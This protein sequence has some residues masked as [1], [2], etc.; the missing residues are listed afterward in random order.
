MMD[1]NDRGLTH[2]AYRM[3]VVTLV[4]HALA[5]YAIGPVP[6]PWLAQMLAMWMFLWIG[7][8]SGLRIAPG[9]VLFVF[10]FIYA[11]LVT[12]YQ[13]IIGEYYRFMPPKA[14]TPYL[15]Y[16]AL[17]FMTMASFGSLVFVT[18]WFLVRGW[19]PQLIRLMTLL[20][21]LV[22]LAALYI[23]FAQIYGFPEP[24][25]TRLGTGGG[26]Q[27]IKFTYA[28][29]RALGTFREPSHLAEWLVLPLFMS[30]ASQ[31]WTSYAA[32][33][34]G[35][36]ALLL[37][38]SLTG[39]G[40]ILGGMAAAFI[41]MMPF[42]SMSVVKSVL[43][44][45]LIGALGLSSFSLF[46]SSNDSK[47]A[48]LIDVLSKRIKPLEEKGIGQSNRNYVY[49]YLENTEILWFGTGMGNSN[50]QFTQ[51]TG[52]DAT[53]SFL[54]L[55][56]NI[57]LSLGYIGLALFIIFLITP[58]FILFAN[59]G[60]KFEPDHFMILAAFFGWLVVFFAHSEELSFHFAMIYALLLHAFLQK[61]P[62]PEPALIQ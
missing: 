51:A 3:L 9:M 27:S 32:R 15:M 20:C 60:Y 5:A 50:L 18:F 7:F 8:K 21:L 56:V 2:T 29:H 24:P 1:K 41:F 37:S 57:E 12:S 17:R 58:F 26:E 55:F 45:V 4:L 59:R 61:H 6:F 52:L 46:V 40:A 30:F 19:K 42:M 62:T 39:I 53:A 47:N 23:Y 14:T 35:V 43:R 28:F 10:F 34:L 36:I 48:D 13:S 16:I 22:S 25:R 38:G 54:N 11:L 33:G 49:S 44:M 31:G